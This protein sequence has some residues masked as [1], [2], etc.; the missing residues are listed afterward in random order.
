MRAVGL[1]VCV[2]VCV[3]DTGADTRV[4]QEKS[5]V[6]YDKKSARGAT[7]KGL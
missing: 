7:A 6:M 2:V 4:Q 1:V 3:A 5:S